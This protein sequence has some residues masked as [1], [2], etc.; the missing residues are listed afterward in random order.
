M[1]GTEK[2]MNNLSNKGEPPT[3]PIYLNLGCGDDYITYLD[4]KVVNVDKNKLVKCDLVLDLE[5]G[6]FPWKDNSIDGIV[7][8]HLVEHFLNPIPFMNECWRVLKP[9]GQIYIEVPA[10]GTVD[11]YKDP[12]HMRPFIEQTFRYFAEWNILPSYGIK[13]WVITFIEGHRG[14]ENENI[15]KVKMQPEKL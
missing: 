7:A 4:I 2:Y 6:S 12:T 10:G 9:D 13:K 8:K 5:K 15:I 1:K 11:Y 3:K 14:G